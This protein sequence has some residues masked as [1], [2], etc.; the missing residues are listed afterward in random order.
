MLQATNTNFLP[1]FPDTII[2]NEGGDGKID[3][4][5]GKTYRVRIISFS[6]FASALLHFDSHTMQ[7]IM[8]DGS[9]TEKEQAYQLRISPAQRYD[10]LI[11]C[12]GRDNR[13]YPYLVSLDINRDFTKPNAVYP[14]NFTGHLV[15][16]ANKPF[17]VDT[18]DDWNPV[19]DSHFK[20]LLPIPRFEPVT[21]NIVL[22]FEFCSDKNGIPRYILNSI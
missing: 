7:V 21:T 12:I 4:A 14:H 16:D 5:K 19:D 8:T 11:S 13:N 6:A 1:P 3:F 20:P 22:D 17:T 9:Y 10:V 15:M 18:V 2:V